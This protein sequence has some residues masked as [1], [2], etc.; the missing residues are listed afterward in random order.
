MSQQ[1]YDSSNDAPLGEWGYKTGRSAPRI[2]VRERL[3]G[4]RDVVVEARWYIDGKRQQKS[5][6]ISIRD[7]RRR[8]VP[9][10][11]RDVEEYAEEVWRAVQAG[12]EPEDFRADQKSGS[13]GDSGPVTLK[14]ACELALATDS[15]AWL[16]SADKEHAERARCCRY[17]RRI[18][19]DDFQPAT[20]LP[21]D[22]T[23]VWVKI[24]KTH[25]KSG[26]D[27]YGYRTCVRTVETL[28]QVCAYLRVNEEIPQGSGHPPDNWRKS[29]KKYWASQQGK[30]VDPYRPRHTEDE[31]AALVRTSRDPA[32]EL[33]PR[34]DAI[35]L[36][37]LGLRAGAITHRA[38]RSGIDW[39]AGTLTIHGS[40]KKAGVVVSLEGPLGSRLR[41]EMVIGYLSELEERYRKEGR[42]YALFPKGRLRAGKARADGGR[43]L[44]SVGESWLNER[45]HDL[46]KA[47]GVKHVEGRAWHGVRRAVVDQYKKKGVPKAARNAAL[48]YEKDSNVPD[49]IYENPVDRQAIKDGQE[50]HRSILDDLSH[51]THGAE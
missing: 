44:E 41:E 20:L 30:P 4:D 1:K 22:W 38:L 21:R 37:V 12:E 46:E 2:T 14:R 19:G 50:A 39:D 31:L 15:G 25:E 16:T 6:G 32:V 49:E 18:L 8:I 29:L 48:G 36:F 26:G 27:R 13:G 45:F 35:V 47:A 43:G 7:D 42:D 10:E 24:W 11:R 9:K 3:E 33:D 34:F 28:S 40:G 17:L 51:K 5:L 23:S